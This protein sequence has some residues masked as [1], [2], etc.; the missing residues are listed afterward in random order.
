VT[1]L[2]RLP[3]YILDV[4]VIIL[5]VPSQAISDVMATLSPCNA[6]L[7]LLTKGLDAA[8]GKPLAVTL[9]W[10]EGVGCLS[11]CSFASEVAQ[12]KPTALTLAFPDAQRASHLAKD[13]SAPTFRLYWTTDVMGVA[14]AGALKNVY[15]IAAG[16]V[17]GCGLGEN[18]RAALI[19][20]S[21]AELTRLG[22][23]MGAQAPTF[24]GLSGLGDMLLTCTSATSRNFRY[25]LSLGQGASPDAVLAEGMFAAQ[26]VSNLVKQYDVE[27]PIAQS[28][29]AI[30][31]GRLSVAEAIALLL[32][33]NAGKEEGTWHTGC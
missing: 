11:G 27:M 31:A 25:G 5:A 3:H 33:R 12:G 13:L 1:L 7:L 10:P 20:R 4:D 2:G 9:S 21:M 29:Q 23:A 18:A 32:Q 30:V 28:V 19:T 16:M 8:T 22:Q 14:L 15:A 24:M 17:T 6:P 26:A